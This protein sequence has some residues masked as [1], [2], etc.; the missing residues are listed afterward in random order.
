MIAIL[1]KSTVVLLLGL[2]F[3]LAA[4][5]S[6]ASVRHL[7]LAAV[8]LFLL[9]LPGVQRFA[10]A[11]DITVQK[12]PAAFVLTGE[13]ARVQPAEPL[14]PVQTGGAS[15]RR[16]IR[17]ADLLLAAYAAVVFLL[18]GRLLLGVLRLRALARSSE[19][20]LE[21]TAR[22]NEIA[23]RASIRRPT[24]VV[25]SS[26]IAVPLTFG[27]I[28]STIVLPA[29][30]REWSA[31]ELT[32]AIRHEL[33]HVRREDWAVQLVARVAAA[34]Y[35]PHPLVWVAWQRLCVE[36]ERACDD[37]VV[38]SSDSAT[39]AEQLVL[40]AKSMAR[41]RALPAL[42]M[43]SP[44]RLAERVHAILDPR[45]RRGPHSRAAAAAAV[46]V[47]LVSLA[48]FGTLRLVADEV[49][50]EGV[51][52]QAIEEGVAGAIG[53]ALVLFREE[54]IRASE[55]GDVGRLGEY[56]DRGG[57]IDTAFPGDGTML[58]IAAKNGHVDA[59]RFLLDRGADP[60]VPSLGDGNPLIAASASGETEI[61]DL[62]L[63]RGA[64]IDE[65]VAG[66]ENALITASR[67]G[68]TEV[69]RLLIERRADVN[70]RVFVFD[71]DDLPHWRTP[72]N[73][74]RRGGHREIERMLL[75]AGAT[76]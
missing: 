64:R 6:R 73:Q 59:V 65:V 39:Y 19:V 51:N 41:R 43:A 66:D 62:L 3:V 71:S 16:S 24:L 52:D 55:R 50:P 31:G 20:W 34:L 29:A 54:V 7:M 46:L 49:V 45:Q 23:L 25:L 18:L 69:V 60:N 15:V 27:L 56:L 76:E 37:A 12:A 11:V 75:A 47:M 17:T 2:T 1:L 70:A 74:A 14:M 48:A 58:L 26:R 40:L 33:E 67:L 36:A 9:L 8:F 22:M 5:R 4:R 44:T 42:P 61:V 30:A 13:P 10:P 68:R 32:R 35:W 38:R 72:L 57:N 63:R 28:R 53:G 21:G